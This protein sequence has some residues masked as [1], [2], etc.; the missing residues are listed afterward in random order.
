VRSRDGQAAADYA[1][2]LLVVVAV[3]LV[4]AAVAVP[5]VGERVI[6][7]VRTGICIVGGDICRS[8]DARAAGLAPCMTSSRETGSESAVTVLSMRVGED[9]R[10]TVAVQSDGSAVVT[11]TDG[12][13]LGASV[14]V[15]LEYSPIGLDVGVDGNVGVVRRSASTWRFRD[16]PAARRF[17]DLALG[18]EPFAVDR[19]APDERWEAFGGGAEGTI[20]GS[21][22][23]EVGAA[24]VSVDGE[25]ASAGGG[26]AAEGLVGRRMGGGRTTWFFRNTLEDPHVYASLPTWASASGTSREAMIEFTTDASGPRELLIRSARSGGDRVEEVTARL[27]L[28]DPD[29]RARVSGGPPWPPAAVRGL[30][31]LAVERGVVERQRYAVD[32][33]SDDFSLAGKVGLAFGVE[34]TRVDVRS[35]LA[36]AEV[37]IAGAGPRRREDCLMA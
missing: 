7:A 4:G 24:N 20:G 2:V 9:G 1:A 18:P 37:W 16:L 35:R 15:G 34:H 19:I 14:G 30:A 23:R 13:S 33:R 36:E 26:A 25:I 5:G 32:D 8:S 29:I 17:L 11:R 22:S 28:R 3:L 10:W 21:V 6:A 31:R 12:K 27:D